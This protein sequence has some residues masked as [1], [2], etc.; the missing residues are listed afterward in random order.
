MVLL[1]GDEVVAVLAV[2]AE[3]EVPGRGVAEDGVA[4]LLVVESVG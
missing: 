4:H 3:Q 1:V 2:V